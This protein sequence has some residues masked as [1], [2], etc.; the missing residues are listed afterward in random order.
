MKKTKANAVDVKK[1]EAYDLLRQIG[2]LSNQANLLREQLNKVE[3][4]IAAL[5]TNVDT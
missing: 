3:Q 1:T 2:S 4:E 5:E